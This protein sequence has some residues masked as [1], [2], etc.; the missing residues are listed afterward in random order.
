MPVLAPWPDVTLRATAA[1]WG[2]GGGGILT[3]KPPTQGSKT[4]IA[5]ELAQ[6]TPVRMRQAMSMGVHESQSLLWSAWQRDFRCRCVCAQV[7]RVGV[8]QAMSMGVH[9]SQSL[10]WERMVSLGRPFSRYLAPKLAAAF[11][12]LA[13][14]LSPETLY[15]ASP[16]PDS[17]ATDLVL[18][19]PH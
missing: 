5:A 7:T 16:P 18:L 4:V 3:P 11:P 8:R 14:K 9:E 10:L 6:V 2:G 1:T 13:D 19:C 15:G 12:Q 17:S